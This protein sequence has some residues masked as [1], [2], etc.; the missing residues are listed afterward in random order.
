MLSASLSLS[1][2]LVHFSFT[3]SLPLIV[4]SLSLARS[5]SVSPSPSH[6]LSLYT[7]RSST[8][9]ATHQ[10]IRALTSITSPGVTCCAPHVLPHLVHCCGLRSPFP[11]RDMANPLSVEIFRVEHGGGFSMP[12]HHPRQSPCWWGCAKD[13]ALDLSAPLRDPP[14]SPCRWWFKWRHME[15]P[16]HR[17]SW[18]DLALLHSQGCR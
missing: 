7:T 1:L 9:S 10:R 18:F 2:S 17:R 11:A 5:L 13:D 6:L 15:S 8:H 4:L 3:L 12:R 14:L 16:E